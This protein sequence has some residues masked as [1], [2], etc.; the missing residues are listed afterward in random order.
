MLDD[1]H[2]FLEATAKR[3]SLPDDTLQKL[4][5]ADAEHIVD[6]ELSDGQSF[7]AY[8]V[9]HNNARGPYKGGIRYHAQV[10]LDEV[11]TLA[12]LMSLKTAA[13]GLPLGGGKGGIAVDPRKLDQ[14]QLEELSRKYVAALH[15]HIGPDK[16][17]PAPDVNTDAVIMDWMVDE[18]EKITGDSSHASFTGKSIKRGGSL[19]RDAATGRGGVLALEQ[20]L[21]L[22]GVDAKELTFAIQGFGNVG[23]YFGTVLQERH[24]DWRLVAASDSEA[25]IY[26]KQGLDASALQKF[27]ADRGRFKDY[28]ATGA[29]IISNDDL[30][31]LDVDVLVLAGFEETVTDK[32]ADTVQAKYAVEMANGPVTKQAHDQLHKGGHIILPD[33]IANAGGVVVSYLEWVQN[34]QGE[35]W[36]EDEVNQKLADYM[37][38]SVSKT[39]RL[40]QQKE[41]SLKDAAFA[42]ALKS[43]LEN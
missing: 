5:Q 38:K 25:A 2:K 37:K 42:V 17:V 15:E 9:Q 43:I 1:T 34:K 13:V 20:L 33:I 10:N 16:D 40:A 29:E 27:K 18:Y 35:S 23:S 30:L 7:K 28:K 41:L 21:K 6:I 8:R 22:D 36:S 14:K 19:G 32:N 31:A 11:R 24:K 39:H 3:L 12:T 4:K 26:A